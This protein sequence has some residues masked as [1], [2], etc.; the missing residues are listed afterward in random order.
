MTIDISVIK[1][2]GVANALDTA[3]NTT[4]NTVYHAATNTTSFTMTA[5][6]MGLTGVGSELAVL[7]CTG[8]LGSGQNITTLTAALMWAAVSNPVA[9]MSYLL[10][11]INNSSGNFAWTV[12]GGTGVTINGTAT[13]AQNTFRDFQV[14]LTSA[15][16][17]AF[18]NIG[19]GTN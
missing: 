16:V 3:L 9:G 15:T 6:Q 11:I 10:R 4:V 13:V 18:Q 14:T 8:A 2:R 12:V 7:D 19:S 5:A 1:D 17:A